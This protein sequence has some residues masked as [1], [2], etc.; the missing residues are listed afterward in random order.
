MS[1]FRKYAVIV[2]GGIGSRM[3]NSIPKQFLEVNNLPVLMHSIHAFHYDQIQIILV[4]SDTHTKL[5]ESLCAKHQFDVPHT[6]VNSGESRFQSVKNGLEYI[7]AKEDN[8]DKVL[9]AIHDGVRPLISRE[10]INTSF[11][12]VISKKAIVPAIESRDSLRL[13]G[14]N[15]QNKMLERQ[16]VRLIQ[17]PQTFY[18]TMLKKAYQATYRSD[19]TDDASVVEKSGYPIHLIEG[20]IRNI[21]ITYPIDLAIAEL[22]M[23]NP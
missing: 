21:K 19:F 2:S 3:N 16:F 12:E 15:N 22:W 9:V 17:T 13:I 11:A 7:F 1:D 4:Q 20:D 8:L 10:L 14:E 5:W 6:Q 23:T 18:G